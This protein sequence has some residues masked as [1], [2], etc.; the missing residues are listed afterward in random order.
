MNHKTSGEKKKNSAVSDKATLEQI[1]RDTQERNGTSRK[2][3]VPLVPA[4]IR[5]SHQHCF[6]YTFITKPLSNNPFFKKITP[7][8][9]PNTANSLRM[10][11]IQRLGKHSIWKYSIFVPLGL[12]E[13]S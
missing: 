11:K 3:S 2:E 13:W 10:P 8:D 6:S 7:I 12:K 1:L 4:D 5:T 9:N